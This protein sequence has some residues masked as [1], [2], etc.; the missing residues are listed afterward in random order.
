M[1]LKFD[2]IADMI[3][4]FWL[5]FDPINNK[6]YAEWQFWLILLCSQ[7]IYGLSVSPF[8]SLILISLD[9]I[10]SYL[11]CKTK[12]KLEEI[13]DDHKVS[14]SPQDDA[15]CDE[16]QNNGV[17][18]NSNKSDQFE[19]KDFKIDPES[20]YFSIFA[21]LFR[22]MFYIPL[23]IVLLILKKLFKSWINGKKKSGK[24]MQQRNQNQNDEYCLIIVLRNDDLTDFELMQIR[25]ETKR[26]ILMLDFGQVDSKYYL[27]WLWTVLKVQNENLTKFVIYNAKFTDKKLFVKFWKSLHCITEEFESIQNSND[28]S[29]EI[30]DPSNNML[31]IKS[32]VYTPH[33]EHIEFL[34]CDLD[35][36]MTESLEKTFRHYLYNSYIEKISVGFV[37]WFLN[38]SQ[39]ENVKLMYRYFDCPGIFDLRKNKF[40]KD[41]KEKLESFFQYIQLII[42]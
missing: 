6:I 21:T 16:F 19:Q 7:I 42:N 10:Q 17:S 37:N 20:S 11:P 29:K 31:K 39:I 40:T 36:I 30:E 18:S 26:N 32:S 33:Y 9:N 23:C 14:D 38:D 3:N 15:K 8:G 24:I 25:N 34:C 4:P 35:E 2:A 5:I 13:V 22:L 12:K 28:L 27:S 41:G 1:I